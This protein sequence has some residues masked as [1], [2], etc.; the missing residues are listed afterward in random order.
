VQPTLQ[1]G[2]RLETE[3]SWPEGGSLT[4]V[5]GEPAQLLLS[6]PHPHQLEIEAVT[7]A[8]TRFAWIDGQHAGILAYR[9]GP[10]LSWSTTAY[11]PHLAP[12]EPTSTGTAD[13]RVRIILVD[14]D[15][16]TVKALHTVRWPREFAAT[17][18]A[19]VARMQDLPFNRIAYDHV[20]AS[21]HRHYPTAEDL[22]ID[23]ADAQC[24]AAPVPAHR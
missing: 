22:V 15:T 6:L 8:P 12:G 10:I 3:H 1:V 17:V 24:V 18:H 20:L 4:M 11:S 9:L 23:R 7:A 21:L 13:P 14:R 2:S 16:D 19:A 5:A